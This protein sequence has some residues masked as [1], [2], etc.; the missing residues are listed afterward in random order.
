MVPREADPCEHRIDGNARGEGR[1]GRP[2]ADAATGGDAVKPPSD[3]F[4][5]LSVIPA[6]ALDSEA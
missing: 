6:R 5:F 3:W 2:G 4:D 1:D